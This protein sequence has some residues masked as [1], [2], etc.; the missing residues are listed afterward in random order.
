M[1][2]I[3][4]YGK[5][6]RRIQFTK[7]DGTR[8]SI[9]LGKVSQRAAE[10]IKLRVERL[11]ESQRLRR[12]HDP[13]M[14]DWLEGLDDEMA[15]KLS[16]VG[17]IPPRESL[18]AATLAE[19]ID[20]YIAGR[21]DVKGDTATVYG[22][23]RRCLVRYFGAEK[24]LAEIAPGDADEWR[25]YLG[26]PKVKGKPASGEGLAENTVR[27]R[28]AIAKQFFRAA[29][30][31]RLIRENPFG[32]MKGIGVK[33][34]RQRD[35]FVTREMAER[36]IEACPDSDWRVIFALSRYGGLR[37][38]S[39][40]L[41]LR[42]SDIDWER[43][44]M[45][46]SSPKTA[47]HE[48]GEFR[49][50]P[51]FPELRKHLDAAYFALGDDP[52]EYVVTRYR[53]AN[54]NLRTTFEKI[55]RRAGLEPWP[56]LFQNLRASRA[57]ELAAEHPAHVAAAWLGHSTLVASKHYWQVTDADFE[58]AASGEQSAAQIA[59]QSEQV[60]TR[61]D[62][63]DEPAAHKKPPYLPVLS[64]NCDSLQ[65]QGM[66]GEGLEPPTSTV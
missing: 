46:V 35:Y 50:V 56:K 20:G 37:C 62:T 12:P 29:Q 5:G 36:I 59:A 40:T 49:S 9:W 28:C 25:R 63:H 22:H 33:E 54:Q 43:G 65:I 38:P 3:S 14:L 45:T 16:G 58:R 64:H 11:I 18:G 27:R 15:G 30:R 39:E 17:L 21:T 51:I 48:G 32:D 4:T 61:S 23:T 19:F 41:A 10:S 60:S 13:E 2:S 24:L 44:R 31:K 6:C 47:H 55:I 7:P 53:S 57:T 42:W 34:N 1:A 26:R 8:P 66:S 52:A